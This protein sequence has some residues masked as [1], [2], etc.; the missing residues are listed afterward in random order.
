MILTTQLSKPNIPPSLLLKFELS[1][2]IKCLYVFAYLHLIAIS[3]CRTVYQFIFFFLYL[4]SST[5]ELQFT[6][7]EAA[8]A[9][10][11]VHLSLSLHLAHFR[12]CLGLCLCDCQQLWANAYHMSGILYKYCARGSLL[13]ISITAFMQ[14]ASTRPRKSG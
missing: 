10:D 7:P 6:V 12:V 2:S 5:D 9:S 13:Y 8:C 4:I 1:C 14:S 3:P 11:F